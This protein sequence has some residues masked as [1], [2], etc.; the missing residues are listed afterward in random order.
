MWSSR[1]QT[2]LF[3]G[4]G[5]DHNPWRRRQ[6]GAVHSNL[7]LTLHGRW[8]WKHE[9]RFS[10]EGSPDQKGGAGVIQKGGMILP[11]RFLPLL[12][13]DRL[14]IIRRYSGKWQRKC[15][16]KIYYDVQFIENQRGFKMS[17]LCSEHGTLYFDYIFLSRRL[18]FCFWVTFVFV[19]WVKFFCVT[20]F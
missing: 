13:E 6:G 11:R 8:G 15:G 12:K 1:P 7:G 2:C 14:P 20:C 19:E 4:K 10:G 3:R 5:W 16:T 9:R 18:T 17:P